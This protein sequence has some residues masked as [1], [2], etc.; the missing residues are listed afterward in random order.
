M[1]E[2]QIFSILPLSTPPTKWLKKERIKKV[3]YIAQGRQSHTVQA[4]TASIYRAR[5]FA[6]I[7]TLAFCTDFNTR[8]TGAVSVIPRYIQDSSQL[9]DTGPIQ[10]YTKNASFPPLTPVTLSTSLHF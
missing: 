1:G 5:T 4:G 10:N 9:M 6:G 7:E 3:C 2:N 8:S